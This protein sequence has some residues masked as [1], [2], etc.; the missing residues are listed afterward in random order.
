MPSFTTIKFIFISSTSI[1]Y[2]FKF[3]YPKA[4]NGEVSKFVY[5]VLHLVILVK[6][7]YEKEPNVINEGCEPES[8]RALKGLSLIITG[9]YQEYGI[10][11][12]F[13]Q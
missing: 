6:P 7:N 9:I 10:G 1:N 3:I 5:E 8:N 12:V 4:Q 2:K 11:I 13:I